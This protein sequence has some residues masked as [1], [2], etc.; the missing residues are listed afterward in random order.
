LEQDGKLYHDLV[1]SE[2]AHASPTEHQATPDKKGWFGR[3]KHPDL[4]GNLDGFI[5]Y[6]KAFVEQQRPDLKYLLGL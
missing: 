2:P 6:R 5:Q 1:N 3:F 4:H